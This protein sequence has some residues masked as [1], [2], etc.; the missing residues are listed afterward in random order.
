[1]LR[2]IRTSWPFLVALAVAPLSLRAADDKPVRPDVSVVV[3]FPRQVNPSDPNHTAGS[4]IF[5]T[6][7]ATCHGVEARGDGPL[8][9]QL[10]V[11]PPDLTLFAHRNGSFDREKVR[12]II[13]GRNPVKGHGGPDMPIWGDVFKQADEGYNEKKVLERLQALVDYLATLQRDR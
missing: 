8:A 7:C 4:S 6:Y 11:R 12:R 3:A 5:K 9:D 13:D 2:P 1:M 10:R